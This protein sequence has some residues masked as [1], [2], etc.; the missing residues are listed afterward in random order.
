[1]FVPLQ[2]IAK[3]EWDRGEWENI[4]ETTAWKEQ[5]FWVKTRAGW[6][7]KPNQWEKTS[8]F[9]GTWLGFI[10]GWWLGDLFLDWGWTV[11][12]NPLCGQGQS[13]WWKAI[14]IDQ[15]SFRCIQSCLRW[16][17]YHLML[18]DMRVCKDHLLQISLTHCQ[19]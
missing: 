5:K 18:S 15:A 12:K 8:L 6:V 2:R 14:F 16:S 7:T 4:R 1:M 10:V 11:G 17:Y 13:Y 9:P 19:S 3:E